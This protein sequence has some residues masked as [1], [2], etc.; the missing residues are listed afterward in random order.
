MQL[1]TAFAYAGPALVGRVLDDLS[2]ALAA[3]GFATVADAVGAD[4]RNHA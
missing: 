1:Y 3:D 2:A 4:L